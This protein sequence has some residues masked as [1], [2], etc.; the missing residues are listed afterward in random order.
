MTTTSPSLLRRL[1]EPN[2]A[3]AWEQFV[4]LYAPLI[5][6]SAKSTGATDDTAAE[7][8]QEV[9][10]VLVVKL[11][12]FEYDHSLKFRAWLHTIT[13]NKIRDH[14]RRRHTRAE[15]LDVTEL[16]VKDQYSDLAMLDEKEY[17]EYVSHQA[18]TLMRAEF[19][20]SVWRACW[21]NLM[22]GIPAA[23][24]AETLGLTV[25]SVYL[26]KSRVLRRLR[27]E[28]DGLLD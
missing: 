8:V 26:A 14:L 16:Q 18:L 24:V 12:T 13:I 11:R 27:E 10:A 15:V 9:M 21:M 28:L 19:P 3:E 20:E 25:N 17:L 6:R 4:R 22:D 23:K 2:D 5:F 1:R 7:I